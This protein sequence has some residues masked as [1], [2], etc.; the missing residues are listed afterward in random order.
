MNDRRLVV[1][2]CA[3]IE[4]VNN[5]PRADATLVIGTIPSEKEVPKLT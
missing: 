1:G 3:D 2:A 4:G 5:R